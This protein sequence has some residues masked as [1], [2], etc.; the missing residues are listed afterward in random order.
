MSMSTRTALTTLAC[1]LAM[2]AGSLTP[3]TAGDGVPVFHDEVIKRDPA[4]DGERLYDVRRLEYDHYKLGDSERLVVKIKFAHRIREGYFMHWVTGYG[5]NENH[6]QITIFWSVGGLFSVRYDGKRLRRI[7]H[8][9]NGREATVTIP[10]RKLG[11][12]RKLRG[13]QFGGNYES[14]GDEASTRAVLE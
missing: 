3:A 10:W 2:I 1:L 11:S 14:T 7:R 4:G 6:K 13:F 12:P 9:I 5:F 8:V